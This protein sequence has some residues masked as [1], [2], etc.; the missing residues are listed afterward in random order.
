MG[1]DTWQRWTESTSEQVIKAFAAYIQ[2]QGL[3]SERLVPWP[4]EVRNSIE[5]AKMHLQIF[6]VEW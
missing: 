3:A 2:S 6:E 5:W 1:W 4:K